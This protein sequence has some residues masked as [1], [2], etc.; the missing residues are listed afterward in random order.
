MEKI[1]FKHVEWED[2]D[3][4]RIS[5]SG[6]REL[7]HAEKLVKQ[8]LAKLELID[9]SFLGYGS[10]YDTGYQEYTYEVSA[11]KFDFTAVDK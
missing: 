10:S 6:G 8:G 1:I 9:R 4:R 7:K 5:R 3:G 2:A 11:H